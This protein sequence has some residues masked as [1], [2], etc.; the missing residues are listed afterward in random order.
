MNNLDE[1]LPTLKEDEIFVCSD[2]CGDCKPVE[3]DFCYSRSENL[4]TGEVIE[5]TH[6]AHKASCC[7]ADLA[8]WN[9][10]TDDFKIL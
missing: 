7:G 1:V 5:L 9:E 10:V 4:K 3:F 8:I 6:K 2:G